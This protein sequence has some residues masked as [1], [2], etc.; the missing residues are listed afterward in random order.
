SRAH[1]VLYAGSA[2]LGSWPATLDLIGRRTRVGEVPATD[3]TQSR[4]TLRVN[5][6]DHDLVLD[7]RTTLLDALRE[8]LDLTGSKKGCDHG[9]CGACTVLVGDRRVNSCL[10]FAVS[11]HGADV[12][13]IEGLAVDGELH[14]LQQSFVAPRRPAVRLLHTGPDL[15]GGGHAARGRR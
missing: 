15:L 2:P 8:H 5:G 7:N 3:E 10:V 14:A 1:A 6:N 12:T 4:V 9:Q 11:V 13:T